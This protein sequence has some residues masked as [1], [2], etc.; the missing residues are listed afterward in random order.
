[1]KI[2]RGGLFDFARPLRDIKQ[3]LVQDRD[4]YVTTMFDLYGLPSDFPGLA[5]S[6]RFRNSY[7][8]VEHL[9]EEM[10]TSVNNRRFIP[11]IQLHEFEGL[12]F[13]DVTAIDDALSILESRSSLDQLRN[14]RAS[15]ASPEEINDGMTTAPSKRLLNLYSSYDKPLFGPLIAERIGLETIRREC[16][17]FNAWLSRLETL[18]RPV[19]EGVQ[20]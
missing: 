10:A 6:K 8:K 17:H 4:A 11:Y 7:H 18:A 20:A 19:R 15:F 2:Y 5:A 13:S 1:M 14:I 12:L 16:Q 9:E 3:W